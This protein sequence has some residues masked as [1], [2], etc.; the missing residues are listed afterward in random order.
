MHRKLIGIGCLLLALVAAPLGGALAQDGGFSPEEQA[1]LDTAQSAVESFFT[2]QS[3]TV[4]HTQSLAQEINVSLGAE[5][6]TI[7]QQIDQQGTTT[8]ERQPDSRFDNQTSTLDQTITQTLRGA[9]AGQEQTLSLAQTLEMIVLDDRAYLRVTT[10]D[11]QM[12]GFFPEGWQ[13]ITEG[14]DAFPGMEV[15]NMEQLLASSSSEFS[16]E[17]FAVLFGA[18]SEIELL[19]PET[20]GEATA[21]RVRLVLDPSAA[22]SGEGANSLREMF[23]TAALP[24][25]VNGLIELIFT[26]EDTHYEITLLFGAEDGQLYG[27][28]VTLNM[29]IAIPAELLTDQTLAGA[30]MSLAQESVSA[31][32][33]TGLNEPAAI[34]APLLEEA[35]LEETETEG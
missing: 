30:D 1:A 12:A 20:I 10:D 2:A 33:F 24:L 29:D 32:R 11:P 9:E 17:M 4:D 28:D 14:A 7:E 22:L 35:E 25:D 6:I 34:S 18:V 26:D 15:Y 21:Q 13:D 5:A 27:Y 23:N 16:A 31:L 19:E 3:Y 8:N